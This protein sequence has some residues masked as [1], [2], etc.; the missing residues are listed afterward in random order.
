MKLKIQRPPSL[1]TNPAPH[2]IH[3]L[4]IKPKVF[5]SYPRPRSRR[6]SVHTISFAAQK[7]PATSAP[8][9]IGLRF[10]T[11]WSYPLR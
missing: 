6:V 8:S 4:A 7:H 9:Q 2:V 1:S 3:N 10:A 5:I 11:E